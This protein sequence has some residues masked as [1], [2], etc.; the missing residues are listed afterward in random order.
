MH[1][2]CMVSKMFS[3]PTAPTIVR[4]EVHV[5]AKPSDFLALN[6]VLPL[7]LLTF[8]A[9]I[10]KLVQLLLLNKRRWFRF[11]R[12]FKCF[13]AGKSLALCIVPCGSDLLMNILCPEHFV[14]PIQLSIK[15]G[16]SKKEEDD[17]IETPFS[18]NVPL[19]D[20]IFM[21]LLP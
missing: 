19:F 5:F 10:Q 12:M 11:F 7:K 9:P 6:C 20:K 21:S 14:S 2:N 4:I 3:C 1:P 16:I 17:K 15:M 8:Y 13:G 18:K